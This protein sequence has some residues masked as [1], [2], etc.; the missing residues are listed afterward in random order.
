M[1]VAIRCWC[2]LKV[3]SHWISS[4][5]SWLQSLKTLANQ[6]QIH[7]TAD[8]PGNGKKISTIF[9]WMARLILKR[10]LN[11]AKNSTVNQIRKQ[12]LHIVWHTLICKWK[13]P[14]CDFCSIYIYIHRL[15]L[16]STK[17]GCLGIDLI[18]ANRAIIFDASWNPSNDVNTDNL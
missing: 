14:N 4:K 5:S 8:L 17:A 15:F 11:I 3:C 1:H 2:F 13:Q 9:D 7:D 18:G 16:L 6:V 12:G 10:V